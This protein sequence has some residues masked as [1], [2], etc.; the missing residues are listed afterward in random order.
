MNARLLRPLSAVAFVSACHVLFALEAKPVDIAA[1]PTLQAAIDANPG[2][3]IHV[4]EGE[5]RIDAALKLTRDG[6]GLYGPARIIQTNPD[7][8]VVRIKGARGVRLNDL[9]LTRAEGKMEANQA[10]IDA[11]NCRDL[12]LSHLQVA[13]NHSHSSILVVDSR[14]VTIADCAVRD[15]KGLAI[16]DRTQAKPGRENLYGYAFKAIDGTGIQ[17]LGCQGAVIRNNRVQ[18]FRFIPTQEL[19]DKYDLGRLTVVPEKRGRLM[20]EAIFKT[21]YTSN[22]HQG[23]GIQVSR[24]ETSARVILT[25]NII[26]NAAQGMD[27]H[28]DYVVVSN[29]IIDRAMIGMK[30]MHGSKHVLINGNQFLHC[31]R[32]GVMV[33]PGAATHLP[34]DASADKPGAEENVDAGTIISN[35]IFSD[36]GWGNDYW[37][38]PNPDKGS[39]WPNVI[40]VL[41]GQLAENPPIHN[42]LVTGNMVY[43]SARD[44]LKID[45]KWQHPAPRYH[46]ALFVDDRRAPLP[47]RVRAFGNMLD[48]GWQGAT[49][50]NDDK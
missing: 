5:Y 1:Y 49:N 28:S 10:G 9:S 20:S 7:E 46:Y 3:M 41:G 43:D 24:P 22:W 47:V 11:A 44:G 14:D 12:E 19:R 16:D 50:Y 34:G 40:A 2:R 27:I 18:E 13:D 45:G 33:M 32:W 48:P 36:F 21:H 26:D 30:A 8:P 29:N 4:P 6:T 17:V 35:N 38:W 39:D 37:N 31:D 23:A 15:Y 42:V 25:G